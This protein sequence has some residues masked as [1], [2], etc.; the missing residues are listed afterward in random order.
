[1]A[2]ICV[3][4]AAGA[5]RFQVGCPTWLSAVGA[6]EVSPARKGWETSPPRSER[7][8]CDTVL[9]KAAER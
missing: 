5:T 3:A 1:M 4:S 6:A 9:E 7:R 2:R 8:R